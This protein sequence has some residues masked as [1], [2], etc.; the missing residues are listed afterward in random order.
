MTTLTYAL[1]DSAIRLCFSSTML[2]IGM[3]RMPR[4]QLRE[5]ANAVDRN[6]AYA[7]RD[8]P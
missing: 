4:D 7:K 8:C 5:S 1:K 3:P 2:R 6:V